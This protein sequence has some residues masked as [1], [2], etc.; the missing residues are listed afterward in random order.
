ME[1]V[2]FYWDL[3][4]HIVSVLLMVVDSYLYIWFIKQHLGESRCAIRAGITYF[5]AILVLWLIP[6]SMWGMTAYALGAVF[7][8]IAMYLPDRSNRNQKIFLSLVIFLIHWISHGIALIPRTLWFN[9]V[10]SRAFIVHHTV[11]EFILYIVIEIIYIAL[12]FLLL[13]LLFG[14]IEKAFGDKKE[15]MSNKELGLLLSTLLSVVLGYFICVFCSEAYLKDTQQYIWRVHTEYDW[16][17]VL[18]QIFSF[19]AIIVSIRFY[20]SIRESLR[21]EKET[22]IL[23]E[24]LEHTKSHIKEMERLYTNIRGMRHDM[25][26]HVMILEKLLLKNESKEAENYLAHLKEQLAE[27]TA[28]IESGNPVTDIILIEKQKEAREKGIAFQ[29]CFH[30][31]QGMGIDAFDLSVILV[32]AL[33]NAIEGAAESVN[34]YV[35]LSSSRNQNVFLIEIENSFCKKLILNQESGLPETTKADEESH[36]FGLL[37]IRNM[38]RK[39]WGDVDIDQDGQRFLLSIMLMGRQV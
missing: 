38:A 11:L 22:M 17:L 33:T 7:I 10:L 16:V 27:S 32:N 28:E 39:Y 23:S 34:P 31:P 3:V 25:G 29:C 4:S 18:Y 9:L 37:N 36:G 15:P 2:E 30:Y 26:N 12:N 14:V 20:H 35:K 24:Q 5:I 1:N 21:K 6:Y 19:A 13:R 8:F